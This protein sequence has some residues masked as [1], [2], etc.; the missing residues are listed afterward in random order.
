MIIMDPNPV[1][2]YISLHRPYMYRVIMAQN[3]PFLS[4]GLLFPEILW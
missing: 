3:Y 2:Y 4:R 1:P